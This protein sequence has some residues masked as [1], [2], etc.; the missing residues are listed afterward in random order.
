MRSKGGI[1]NRQGASTF[2]SRKCPPPVNALA[3]LGLAWL[4]ILCS[5]RADTQNQGNCT[6]SDEER[7]IV[8]TCVVDEFHKVVDMGNG[9]VDVFEFCE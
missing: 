6:R 5:A 1:S 9:V 3:W 2:A 4:F 7:C 8:E